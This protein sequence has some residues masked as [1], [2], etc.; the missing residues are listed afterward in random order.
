MKTI[1]TSAYTNKANQSF[2]TIFSNITWEHKA[3]DGS[4]VF[5]RIDLS[6]IENKYIKEAIEFL[7]GVE[8]SAFETNAFFKSH[9][10]NAEKQYY[11]LK[12]IPESGIEE[13]ALYYLADPQGYTYA[14]YTVYLENY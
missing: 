6:K 9:F 8:I 2:N 14:R 1:K 4:E 7:D 10:H 12:E 11:L 5:E 3:A 13:D